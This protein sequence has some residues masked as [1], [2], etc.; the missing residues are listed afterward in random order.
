MKHLAVIGGFA[1]FGL[2]PLIVETVAPHAHLVILA[3]AL[4]VP[5]YCLAVN[6]L[7]RTVRRRFEAAMNQGQEP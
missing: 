4:G 1:V 3:L 7:D 6:R 2:L 5:T